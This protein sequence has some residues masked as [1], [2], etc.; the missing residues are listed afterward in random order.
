MKLVHADA[1]PTAGLL[2]PPQPPSRLPKDLPYGTRVPHDALAASLRLLSALAQH[3]HHPCL[4]TEALAAQRLNP[5]PAPSAG[6]HADACHGPNSDAR[7][8][9]AD[10]DAVA[11]RRERLDAVPRARCRTRTQRLGSD[12]VP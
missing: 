12:G 11:Q 3:R 5:E 7:V 10:A 6:A 9:L 1:L 2:L 4:A 8:P